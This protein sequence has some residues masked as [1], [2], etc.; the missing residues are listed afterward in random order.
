M[1]QNL[2][3]QIRERFRLET[4]LIWLQQQSETAEDALRQ[5]KY[6]LRQAEQE[7]VLYSGS[8]RAFRDKL[9]GKREERELTLNRQ[10]Q[11]ARAHLSA[12][13][14]EKTRLQGAMA[15]VREHLDRLPGLTELEAEA[16]G[17]ARWELCRLDSL[18]TMDRLTP[19]LEALL[20][21]LDELRQIQRG[22]RAGEMKNRQEW[23]EL[24]TNPEQLASDLGPL[25]Q[26]LEQRLTGLEM[27][28]SG[29]EF[30]ENPTVFLN[31]AAVHNRLDRTGKAMAQTEGLLKEFRQIREKLDPEQN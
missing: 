31:P 7:Q 24:R 2:M 11:Q 4:S 8:F 13:S 30:F 20:R 1:K 18:L 27:E 19:L 26:N 16:E 23:M 6:D 28:F 29:G 25:L 22:Q 14:Q 9:T 10:V 12:A 21:S 15:E 3:E 17:N 5:A